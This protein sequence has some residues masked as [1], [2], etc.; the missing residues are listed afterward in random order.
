M[1]DAVSVE[2][3]AK[4]KRS[5]RKRKRVVSTRR[6]HT[7]RMRH[8]LGAVVCVV[9]LSVGG[10]VLQQMRFSK[11]QA[12]DEVVFAISVG[13]IGP[14]RIAKVWKPAPAEARVAMVEQSMLWTKAY[15]ATP[16]FE[17]AYQAFRQD[18][19]PDDGDAEALAEWKAN[20]PPT[21]RE[22]VKK[23][24]REFLRESANV[25]YG[26]KLVRREGKMRFANAKYEDE[27]SGEWKLCYRAGQE[28]VTKARAI[29]QS[30]LKE[31][32]AKR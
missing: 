26:A 13:Q 19:K 8:L 21:G 17:Q 20:F 2:A 16:Q 22:A 28:P 25:D 14:S 5:G 31:L 10:D 6:D 24:L 12:E 11:S 18:Y 29:A 32:E 7:R 30:W 3:Q 23:R 9:A 1:R 27:M 15:T 4:R